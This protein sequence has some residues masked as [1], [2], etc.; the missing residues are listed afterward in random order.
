[1]CIDSHGSVIFGYPRERLTGTAYSIHYAYRLP[2]LQQFGTMRADRVLA[3]EKTYVV[4]NDLIRCYIANSRYTKVKVKWQA[5]CPSR[6]VRCMSMS[7]NSLLM[8]IDN[9]V[10]ARDRETGDILWQQ[11]DLDGHV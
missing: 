8:G 11:D 4:V 9:R 1:M 2:M 10:T 5:D 7:A 6:S 3:D